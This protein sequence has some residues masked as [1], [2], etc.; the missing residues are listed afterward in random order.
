MVR[1]ALAWKTM[2]A[3][4]V[5]KAWQQ[6]YFLRTLEKINLAADGLSSVLS[7]EHIDKLHRCMLSNNFKNDPEVLLYCILFCSIIL[8]PADNQASR[9]SDFSAIKLLL[10]S[11]GL[12]DEIVVHKIF[13][14]PHQVTVI[15]VGADI[16]RKETEQRSWVLARFQWLAQSRSINPLNGWGY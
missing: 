13:G 2:T 14:F 3:A 11:G 7:W 15:P 12:H 5:V 6:L 8:Y 10:F 1:G 4:L 16:M 9:C